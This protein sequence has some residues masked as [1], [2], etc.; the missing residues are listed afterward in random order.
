M[1]FVGFVVFLIQGV[2]RVFKSKKLKPVKVIIS[3]ITIFSGICLLYGAI[4]SYIDRH[5]AE[6]VFRKYKNIKEVKE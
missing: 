3:L 4:V 6:N 5:S 2:I 1:S